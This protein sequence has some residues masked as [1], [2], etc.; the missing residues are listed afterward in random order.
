[1]AKVSKLEDKLFPKPPNTVNK[2]PSLGINSIVGAEEIV[3]LRSDNQNL[4]EKLTDL[5]KS[6]G[7]LCLAILI[8]FSLH[9]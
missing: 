9:L 4:R 5:Q 6:V 8:L 3:K 1:M 7:V 2:L